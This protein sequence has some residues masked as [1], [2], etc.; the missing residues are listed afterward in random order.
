[1]FA[2]V[3]SQLQEYTGITLPSPEHANDRAVFWAGKLLR[4]RQP[5]GGESSGNKLEV[6]DD[7]CENWHDSNSD[8]CCANT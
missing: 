6:S 7:Q 8:N 3:V 5:D 4:T 1:M 2:R